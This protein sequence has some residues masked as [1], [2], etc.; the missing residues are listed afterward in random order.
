MEVSIRYASMRVPGVD[1][2]VF[3]EEFDYVK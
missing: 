2:D 1:G 3:Y